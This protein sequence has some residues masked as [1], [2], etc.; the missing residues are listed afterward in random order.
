[1][2]G[3]VIWA[4]GTR[5]DDAARRAAGLHDFFTEHRHIARGAAVH[6]L[7]AARFDDDHGGLAACE[8]VLRPARRDRE[9]V[10]LAEGAN[11]L[12]PARQDRRQDRF[13]R[14]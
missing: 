10:G 12:D 3:R 8:H 7:D 9:I 6:R 5:Y 2:V 13:P 14:R 11:G 4:Y 1:M